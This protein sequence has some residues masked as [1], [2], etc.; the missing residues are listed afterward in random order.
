MGAYLIVEG[1]SL[2]GRNR[3]TE[4]GETWCVIGVSAAVKALNNSPG[5]L[6]QSIKD[7]YVK[8]M[9][10]TSDNDF[11]ILSSDTDGNQPSDL[12]VVGE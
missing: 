9:G 10:T 4:H 3:I 6:L 2:L 8:W 11:A 1:L 7:G 12:N 5:I